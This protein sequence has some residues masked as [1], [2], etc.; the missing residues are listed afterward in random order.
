VLAK[1][2]TEELRLVIENILENASNYSPDGKVINVGLAATKNN[3]AKISI[4]DQGV[5]IDKQDIVKLFHKF[6]RINNPLSNAVNGTGLGLY[7]SRKIVELAARD[8][9]LAFIPKKY[10]ILVKFSLNLIL[11]VE[12]TYVI[13]P[14]EV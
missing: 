4:K 14:V 2:D 5:G 9:T 12:Y 1:I 6:S 11:L 8:L 13:N 10:V 3:E 7:F